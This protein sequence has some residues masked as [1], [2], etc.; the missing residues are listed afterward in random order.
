MCNYLDNNYCCSHNWTENV[1]RELYTGNLSAQ[2]FSDVHADTVNCCGTFRPSTKL[3]QRVLDRNETSRLA[4][5]LVWAVTWQ[6]WCGKTNECKHTDKCAFSTSRFWFLFWTWKISE[7]GHTA[8]LIDMQGK[9]INLAAWWT[10]RNIPVL[11]AWF[12]WLKIITGIC[13]W[14]T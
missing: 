3:I 5:R 7:T 11:M 6:P 12:L 10:F 9:W 14:G 1:G 2:L 8:R 4:Y 13:W